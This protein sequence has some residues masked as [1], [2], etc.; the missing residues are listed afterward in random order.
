M[1]Y[2]CIVLVNTRDPLFRGCEATASLRTLALVGATESQTAFIVSIYIT[3][4]ALVLTLT[5]DIHA[6]LAANPSIMVLL[7]LCFSNGKK[8]KNRVFSCLVFN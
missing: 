1:L 6:C 2:C 7:L 4:S 5:I 8:V 3:Y